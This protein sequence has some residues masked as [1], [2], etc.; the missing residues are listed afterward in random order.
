MRALIARSTAAAAAA[1]CRAR[2]VEKERVKEKETRDI[3]AAAEINE[4]EFNTNI[5]KTVD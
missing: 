1:L 5:S 3:L 2:S 4:K